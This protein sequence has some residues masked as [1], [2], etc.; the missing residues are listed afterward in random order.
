MVWGIV[1]RGAY[2]AVRRIV[3]IQDDILKQVLHTAPTRNM[4]GR[5]GI[6]GVRHGLAGGAASTV[7]IE[8]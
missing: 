1:A 4:L 6:R 5:G 7:F 3:N 8:E 2:H